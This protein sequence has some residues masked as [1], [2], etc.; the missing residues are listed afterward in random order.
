MQRTFGW[1]VRRTILAFFLLLL[2]WLLL[3][4]LPAHRAERFASR[5]ERIPKVGVSAAEFW[6]AKVCHYRPLAEQ[7][8]AQTERRVLAG[9]L[10]AHAH[11]PDALRAAFDEDYPTLP[12]PRWPAAG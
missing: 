4:L 12:G 1:Y 7:I 9:E 2:V 8:I 11:D 5:L 10:G 6:R 3:G